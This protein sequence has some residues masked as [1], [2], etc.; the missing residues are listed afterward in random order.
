M[1]LLI[2]LLCF[3]LES[4]P[5]MAVGIA[6]GALLPMPGAEKRVRREQSL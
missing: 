5:W 1:T 6:A 4:L 3:P 2:M